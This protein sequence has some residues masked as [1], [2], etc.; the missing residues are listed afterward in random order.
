LHLAVAID[1]PNKIWARNN[2]L[3]TVPL[4]IMESSI[5][6]IWVKLPYKAVETV[7]VGIIVD[8]E[9]M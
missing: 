2:I 9:I 7:S 4:K 1:R 3:S 6:P 5:N 8:E